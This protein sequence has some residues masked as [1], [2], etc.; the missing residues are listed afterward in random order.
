MTKSLVEHALL[1]EDI[2]AIHAEFNRLEE[3]GDELAAEVFYDSNCYVLT[4]YY[5]DGRWCGE[6]KNENGWT[7]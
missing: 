3:S 4:N 7:P 6:V 5:A 2:K 1:I